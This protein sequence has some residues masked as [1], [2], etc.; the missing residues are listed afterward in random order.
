MNI[1]NSIRRRNL[2][3]HLVAVI[4]ASAIAVY[5]FADQ[6]YEPI[7]KDINIM[8]GVIKSAFKNGE[9]CRS[10]RVRVTGH[11]LANQ[12]VVFH[13]RPASR[14]HLHGFRASD[15]DVNVE[16]IAEGM[17]AIP[18]VVEDVL[19][20]VEMSLADDDFSSFR[21]RTDGDWSRESRTARQAL[22]EARSALREA[23][24]ELREVEI[25]AIH[26]GGDELTELEQRETEILQEL[27]RLSQKETQIKAD[28][29]DRVKARKDAIKEKRAQRREINRQQL[30]DME[31]LVLNT[32]CD[33]GNT[34]RN[35]PKKE[36]ISVIFG[37]HEEASNIHVFRQADLDA[38]D[39]SQT[40]I[41]DHA[42]SYVF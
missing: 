21:I 8:I 24:R 22:R 23:R 31:T 30:Q 1:Q 38:C 14:G 36:H 37:R 16:A 9:D 41:R 17:A 11:Y 13:V 12:G 5:S 33:Y 32:F 10:C 27:E 28:L 20:G 6:D 42:L 3:L 40:D 34:M 25:E 18:L 26:A 15:F 35:L 29:A 39:S 2:I 7:R 4:T 19:E